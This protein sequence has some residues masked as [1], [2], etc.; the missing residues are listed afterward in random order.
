MYIKLLEGPSWPWSYG[1]WNYNYLCNQYLSPLKLWD[2]IRILDTTLCDKPCQSLVLGRWFS[3]A[4]PVS[5]TNKTD[6][7]DIAEILLKVVLNT[8]A[9]TITLTYMNIIWSKIRRNTEQLYQRKVK[10]LEKNVTCGTYHKTQ[11]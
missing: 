9:L 1:T 2:Q 7:H 5:S 3:P 4:T 10:I 8:I 11:I 6:R